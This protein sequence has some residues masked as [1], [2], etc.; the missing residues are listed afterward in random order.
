MVGNSTIF[1][2]ESYAVLT[3]DDSGAVTFTVEGP[4]GDDDTDNVT[5]DDEITFTL[6]D[7]DDTTTN[8]T[9]ATARVRWQD[10]VRVP[11]NAT[12]D[13]GPAYQVIDDEAIGF[14]VTVR[15]Y[16]QYGD[17]I[18]TDET[19]DITIDSAAPA[20]RPISSRGVATY[21]ASVASPTAGGNVPVSVLI[22]G[23]STTIENDDVMPVEH[24]GGDL[25]NN[26]DIAAVYAE[27]NRFRIGGALY[28]YDSDDTF[29]VG[30]AVVDMVGFEDE[31]SDDDTVSIFGYDDDGSSVFS[32][33]SGG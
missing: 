20:N 28:T 14:R 5:R 31:L 4:G 10:D 26:G 6:D 3:T 15:L 32:L 21:S 7:D 24:A 11:N 19:A 33:T 8:D 27:D 22:T 1:T 16:D 29:L 2:N 23:V 17:P 13:S 25:V 12:V 9:N 30:N 18:G